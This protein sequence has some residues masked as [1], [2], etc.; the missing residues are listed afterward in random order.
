MYPAV[1]FAYKP[2]TKEE[3]KAFMEF[4]KRASAYL[5]PKASGSIGLTGYILGKVRRIRT[6][7]NLLAVAEGKTLSSAWGVT[8]GAKSKFEKT[9]MRWN[10]ATAAGTTPMQLCPGGAFSKARLMPIR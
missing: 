6:L 10:I 2:S 9:N 8:L 1:P 3:T 7:E 4:Q 5:A